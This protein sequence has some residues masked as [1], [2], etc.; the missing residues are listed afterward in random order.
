MKRR[1]VRLHVYPH[2]VKDSVCI[3]AAYNI[4]RKTGMKAAEDESVHVYK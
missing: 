1:E 3:S 2:S 4:F